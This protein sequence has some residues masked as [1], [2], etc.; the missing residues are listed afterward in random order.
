MNSGLLK[1]TTAV[2]GTYIYNSMSD[3]GFS[4]AAGF[5]VSIVGFVMILITNTIA[6]KISEESSLF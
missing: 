4:T 3:V 5:Y 2:L 6:K 1:S